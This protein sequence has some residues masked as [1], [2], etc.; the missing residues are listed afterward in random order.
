MLLLHPAAT[1]TDLIPGYLQ[2][3]IFEDLAIFHL[4][5]P[6]DSVIRNKIIF[7]QQIADHIIHLPNLMPILVGDFNCVTDARDLEN[8]SFI[9]RSFPF[10]T[11]YIHVNHFCDS[12]RVLHP[13]TTRFSWYRRGS[14][15]ACLDHIYFPP[16]GIC[17]LC[18]PL[19]PHHI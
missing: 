1:V 19:Y 10:L 9:H 8:N 18:C 16:S 5:A 4:Y 12:F 13:T 11:D 3:V 2:K 6:S 17:F 14:A 15:A 7:F